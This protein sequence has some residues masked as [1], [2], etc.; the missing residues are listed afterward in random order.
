MANKIE[1][2]VGQDLTSTLNGLHDMVVGGG[3]SSVTA[4]AIGLAAFCVCISLIK[5]T[6]DYINGSSFKTWQLYKP[7]VMF[8]LVAGFPKLVYYPVKS[9]CGAYNSSLSRAVSNAQGDYI[10]R[11]QEEQ[12]RAAKALEMLDDD[13]IGSAGSGNGEAK[14]DRKWYDLAGK[15]EDGLTSLLVGA[16]N[17][18]KRSICILLDLPVDKTSWWGIATF[19]FFIVFL[20]FGQV[21]II[22][23]HLNMILLAIIGPFVFA[24]GI[25]PWFPKGPAIWIEKFIQFS[26]WHP[27]VYICNF[28]IVKLM[29]VMSVSSAGYGGVIVSFICM[30]VGFSLIKQVPVLAGWII[31]GTSGEFLGNGAASQAGSMVVAPIKRPVGKVTNWAENKV[32]EGIQKGVS[33]A[34]REIKTGAQKVGGAIKSRFGAKNP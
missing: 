15:A 21:M 17:G 19:L 33:A 1:N 24:I 9:V 31:E 11:F 32:G 27:L 13:T 5:I 4:A 22:T 26:F 3:L 20:F 18:I 7:I 2:M 16:V 28:V 8:I 10:T 6:N 30:V 29:A 25:L 34:G 23:A 14:A 12:K